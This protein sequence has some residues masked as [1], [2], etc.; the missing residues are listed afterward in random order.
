MRNPITPKHNT[1]TD[2]EKRQ[3]VALF[4]ILGVMSKVSETTGIPEP[5]LCAWKNET[6]W[7]QV[8]TETLR[9]ETTHKIRAQI[10]DVI[11]QSFREVKDR[12]EYGDYKIVDKGIQRVPVSA[13]DAGTLM[14][15]MFDK[16]QIASHQPT[17]ITTTALDSRL[18][19]MLTQFDAIGRELEARTIDAELVKD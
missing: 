6:E 4:L 15:I 18:A 10:D 16:R 13:R 17:S 7:W 9:S 19:N 3:A 12:L 5:T 8:I 14:A 1:Y 11:E 2:V